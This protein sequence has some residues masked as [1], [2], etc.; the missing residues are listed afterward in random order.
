MH[1]D[2]HQMA[3]PVTEALYQSEGKPALD[4]PGVP[5]EGSPCG[6]CG[7]SVPTLPASGVLTSRFGSWD[8]IAVDPKEGGRWLCVPCAWAY[9]SV[10]L[11]R[12]VTLV[13]VDGTVHRPTWQQVR[14]LLQKP[15]PLEQALIVP[16]SGKRIVAPRADWGKVTADCGPISW[17]VSH[18]ALLNVAVFLRA[19]GFGEHHLAA[20]SPPFEVMVKI[21]PGR[22]AAIRRAWRAFDPARADKVMLPLFQRLTRESK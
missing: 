5:R 14:D 10:P 6:S 3:V 20:Q 2:R 16:V 15:L 19:A 8:D 11:R 18:R 21:E 4:K 17:T 9:R 1:F 12:Q 13:T 7:R 22:H